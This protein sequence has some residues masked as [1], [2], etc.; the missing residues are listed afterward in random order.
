MRLVIK[1]PSAFNLDCEIMTSDLK[2]RHAEMESLR[3]EI[4]EKMDGEISPED[5]HDVKTFW[6]NVKNEMQDQVAGVVSASVFAKEFFTKHKI[7]A[8]MDRD[9]MLV[10]RSENYW[11]IQDVNVFQFVK[12]FLFRNRS[13]IG[14]ILF[15]AGY[16]ALL[17]FMVSY[18]LRR[19]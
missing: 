9:I 3:D 12:S 5:L 15:H 17:I 1:V 2:S 13:S 14:M 10:G 8:E 19:Q 11:V 18:F 4:K 16:S 6:V 7:G